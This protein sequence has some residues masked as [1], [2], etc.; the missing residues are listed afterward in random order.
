[1]N[2]SVLEETDNIRIEIVRK[3][4]FVIGSDNKR[5]YLCKCS[6]ECSRRIIDVITSNM[7]KYDENRG[8]KRLVQQFESIVC[9]YH[10]VMLSGEYW[11]IPSG[12][13]L[14]PSIC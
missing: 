8:N 5:L 7:G 9:D 1:M 2:K 11:V 3:K 12:E 4:S 14:R 10:G 13:T 6:V